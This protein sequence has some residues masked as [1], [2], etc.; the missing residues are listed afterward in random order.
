M[1]ENKTFCSCQGFKRIV[2]SNAAT[3]AAADVDVDVDDDFSGG[4]KFK[5]SWQQVTR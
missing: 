3:I 2:A 1:K 4:R 5:S